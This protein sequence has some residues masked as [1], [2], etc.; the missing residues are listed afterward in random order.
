VEP[1]GSAKLPWEEVVL[2]VVGP[3]SEVGRVSWRGCVTGRNVSFKKALPIVLRGGEEKEL[4]G[5]KVLEAALN[6]QTS[7]RVEGNQ[8]TWAL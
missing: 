3:S 1:A 4:D 6:R 8:I 7:F 5:E 2:P